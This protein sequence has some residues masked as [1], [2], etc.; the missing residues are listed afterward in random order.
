MHILFLDKLDMT[1]LTG[2]TVHK[3]QLIKNLSELN[4]ICYVPVKNNSYIP[5][6]GIHYFKIKGGALRQTITF[7]QQLSKRKVNILYTRN[8]QAGI[9][10]IWLKK[11]YDVKLVYEVNGILE[12]EIKMQ[13]ESINSHNSRKRVKE[14][15]RV[16]KAADAIIAVSQQISNYYVKRGIP[17]EK[18]YIIENGVDISI[19]KHI[20][21]AHKRIREQLSIPEDTKIILFVGLFFNWQGI[22]LLIKSFKEV[23]QHNSKTF[24]ILIGDGLEREKLESL[25]KNL[26]LA[27]YV[28]FTGRV[29]YDKI[30]EYISASNVCISLLH[31]SKSGALKMWEYLACGRPV[32]A[33]RMSAYHFIDKEKCGLLAE[34]NNIEETAKAIN[35]LLDNPDEALSMGQNGRQ[36]VIETHTWKMTAEKTYN[37]FKIIDG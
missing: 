23:R 10:G 7:F 18:I 31:P 16:A 35:H 27:N 13:H 15:L 28:I 25:S 34:Y 9:L 24:L 26:D 8:H 5:K 12:E 29:A 32:V 33:T 20:E 22:D 11:I 3:W 2:A 14:D 1:D 6:L 30:P 37:V 19:F 4:Q 21:N 36:Y 17:K